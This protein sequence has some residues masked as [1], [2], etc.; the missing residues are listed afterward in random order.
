MGDNRNMSS[1]SRYWG[2]VT[3][4]RIIAKASM[5]FMPFNRMGLLH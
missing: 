4:E 3:R 2:T 5:I 1:D